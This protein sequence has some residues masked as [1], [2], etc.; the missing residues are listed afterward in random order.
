MANEQTETMEATDELTPA[1]PPAPP[2]PKTGTPRERRAE[3]TKWLNEA[4]DR[5]RK[6]WTKADATKKVGAPLDIKPLAIEDD[7]N[8][9]K[10]AYIFRIAGIEELAPAKVCELLNEVHT[11]GT[12]SMA[13]APTNRTFE[14]VKGKPSYFVCELE[15]WSE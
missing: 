4:H 7:A 14:P 12:K 1:T 8:G 3:L 11:A 5:L 9:L 6:V 10:L 13:G 15:W 2:A